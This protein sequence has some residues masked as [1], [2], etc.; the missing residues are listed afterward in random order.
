MMKS[1]DI[2]KTKAEREQRRCERPPCSC[3]DN[4][5]QGDGRLCDGGALCVTYSYIC[6]R[7]RTQQKKNSRAKIGFKEGGLLPGRIARLITAASF[8]H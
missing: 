5:K 1:G 2:S 8:N 3:W 4:P 6:D 7:V